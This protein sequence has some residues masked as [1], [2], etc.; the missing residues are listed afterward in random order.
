MA[1]FKPRPYQSAIIEHIISHPRCA[2]FAGMGMG[3]T[4]SALAAVAALKLLGDVRRVLI[5]APLRVAAGT[6]PS[7]V[8]K[9]DFPLSVAVCN[10]SPAARRQAL[11]SGADVVTANYELLS[12]LVAEQGAAWAFDMIIADES[13][14]LKS[15]RLGGG[16]GSRAKSLSK[17]AWTAVRRFVLL[18]GTPAPNGLIDLWGQLWFIDR[19]ERLGRSFSAFR[20]QFFT[21]RRVGASAFAVKLEPCP[22]AQAEIEKRL[23]DCCISL[24][25]E[26][27]FPLEQPVVMPVPVDLPD[28]VRALYKQV[29]AQMYAE[30]ST[31]DVITAVS[32][33]ARTVKC[34]QIASGG[35]YVTD[36]NTGEATD[37]WQDLHDAKIEALRSIQEETAG[38]P[39]LVVYHWRFDLIKLK[40]AFPAGR[41]MDRRGDVIAAWNRG[42]VPMLFVHP[43]SA[44]HG[45]NLQD[46]GRVVVMYS[47][48]WDLE[49]YQQV[50]ERVGPVRQMQSGHPR[51]VLIYN[52]IARGTVDQ[53]VIKRMEGKATVQELLMQGLKSGTAVTDKR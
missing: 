44:G 1:I 50:I 8:A 3:K 47:H 28:S 40:K 49:Q 53:L 19:G 4:S 20:G 27:Y 39:L 41:E 14:R 46:G 34:L 17:V 45:L 38:E 33:A 11:S 6:W 51:S 22:W 52:I 48:W 16:G 15:F 25:P 31:G 5:L 36:A 42:E 18:T 30:L 26:D 23:Q 2:V 37:E 9:W 12:W 43:A 21:Q 7:E 35:C 24:R 29:E 32:A 10:G 13:T